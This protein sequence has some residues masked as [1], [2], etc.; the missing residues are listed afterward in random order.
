[1]SNFFD[2]NE[3]EVTVT[4]PFLKDKPMKFFLRMILDKEEKQAR[5]AFFG[6]SEAEREAREH[7]YNV[8]LLAS[9]STK[10]PE[11][12]PTFGP[13]EDV[14]PAEAIRHFFAGGNARKQKLVADV[15]TLYF[16]EVQPRE[17]FRGV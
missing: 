11:N 12:V 8:N 14:E 1:M 5:Q 16:S 6:L 4:Y 3:I 10:M 2:L 9:L 7:E 13:Y 15:V 17:F